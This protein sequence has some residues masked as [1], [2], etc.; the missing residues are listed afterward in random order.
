[1]PRVTPSS[2]FVN[3]A[4][5]ATEHQLAALEM[6]RPENRIIERS[7]DNILV[8]ELKALLLSLK[9]A[10]QKA[11]EIGP[12]FSARCYVD[13]KAVIAFCNRGRVK[14]TDTTLSIF[15]K[16]NYLKQKELYRERFSFKAIYIPSAGNPADALSR[17]TLL[18]GH[19]PPPADI[20]LK[21][22]EML[23]QL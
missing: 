21:A 1:M 20:S 10:D 2:Q 4:S 19:L 12:A 23:T 9:L 18:R 11:K 5:D 14:W 3:F 8:N 13:N 22:R 17:M 7:E 15:K 16:F 6:K